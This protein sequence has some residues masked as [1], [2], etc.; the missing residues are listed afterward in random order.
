MVMTL[1]ES[2]GAAGRPAHVPEPGR[3]RKQRA[4]TGAE[5]SRPDWAPAIPRVF[6]V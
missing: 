6:G 1:R 4:E 2:A 3:N 5:T